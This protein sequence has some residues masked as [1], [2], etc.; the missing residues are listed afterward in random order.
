MEKAFFNYKF[1]GSQEPRSTLVL[2]SQL[3]TNDYITVYRYFHVA[4]NVVEQ[5]KMLIIMHTPIAYTVHV[6]YQCPE[7]SILLPVIRGAPSSSL[8]HHKFNFPTCDLLL[9]GQDHSLKVLGES[10]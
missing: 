5:Y 10:S 7:S 1:L 2:Q 4:P 9:T 3:C 6:N 8:Y